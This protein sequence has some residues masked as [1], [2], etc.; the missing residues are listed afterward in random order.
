MREKEVLL[1]FTLFKTVIIVSNIYMLIL[2]IKN[3]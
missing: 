1:K 3:L 2:R